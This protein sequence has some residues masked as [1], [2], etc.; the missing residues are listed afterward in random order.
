MAAAEVPQEVRPVV[1][2]HPRQPTPRLT[3]QLL[4]TAVLPYLRPGLP[5]VGAHPLPVCCALVAG[6]P[7]ELGMS[8]PHAAEHE[9]VMSG[10][11]MKKIEAQY[12]KTAPGRR[13][14]EGMDTRSAAAHPTARSQ[15]VR[16][17]V[18]HDLR[19]LV[20]NRALD[21]DRSLHL[22]DHWHLVLRRNGHVHH[23]IKT[24]NLRKLFRVLAPG[25]ATPLAHHDHVDVPDIHGFLRF[26]KNG[27]AHP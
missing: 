15:P 5:T 18:P 16:W 12:L 25:V 1:P 3:R 27:S 9:G 20:T 4:C 13:R 24:P 11:G 14:E 26:L 8:P 7:R 10:G 21:L 2:A 23:P 19:N 6:S 22:S 17:K